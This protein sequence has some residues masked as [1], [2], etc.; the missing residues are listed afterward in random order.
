M[1]DYQPISCQLHSEYELL[2]MNR[3]PVRVSLA[4]RDTPLLGTIIDIKARNGAEFLL[5]KS[6]N[7]ET[8]LRLDSITEITKIEN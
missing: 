1:T 3:T 6:D 7:K 4:G 2:A 5:L 8:E